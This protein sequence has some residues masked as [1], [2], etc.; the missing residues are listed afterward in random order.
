MNPCVMR[1]YTDIFAGFWSVFRLFL[2]TIIILLPLALWK[3]WEI[4]VWFWGKIF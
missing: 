1:E 4:V 3:L 2:A